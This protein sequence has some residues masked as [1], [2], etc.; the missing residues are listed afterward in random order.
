MKKT[1]KLFTLI[2]VAYLLVLPL[3]SCDIV[4]ETPF[5]LDFSAGESFNVQDVERDALHNFAVV[6]G[7]L[8]G[9]GSLNV[10]SSGGVLLITPSS[11]GAIYATSDYANVWFLYDGLYLTAPF[12]FVSG[13]QFLITWQYTPPTST[14]II[15]GSTNMT[16][17]FRSD[18]YETNNV[19]AYGLDSTNT[20][21]AA[22]VTDTS[23]G[24][25]S[26]TY[27]FRIWV[28][29]YGGS[30]TELTSGTPVA[31]LVRTSDG[32]GYQ[33]NTWLPSETTLNLGY[34]ALKIII[35]L[36]FGSGDW[37]SRASYISHPLINSLMYSQTWTFILYTSKATSGSTTAYFKFGSVSTYN[38]RITGIGFREPTAWEIQTWRINSGDYIGFVLGAYVD[39]I[40]VAAY[41]LILLI[42]C[43]SLYFRYR[44]FWAILFLFVIFGGAGG[45]IWAIVPIWAAAVIDAL[46]ILGCSFLVWKVIR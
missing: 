12:A 17:Y 28:V 16:L 32:T 10:T 11:S 36:K 15:I 7:S 5:N 22:T 24:D 43:G 2:A 45:I 38:S 18:E 21:V 29:H 14:P 23:A 30:T 33:N 37:T 6:S 26:V 40:G 31:Q 27:G 4:T 39:E 19:T 42:P 20:N 1:V 41:L 34:D 9:T 46:L 25:V 44:N 13:T 8:T 3:A 35:Y